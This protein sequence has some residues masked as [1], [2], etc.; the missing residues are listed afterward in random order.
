MMVIMLDQVDWSRLAVG[1]NAN[2]K[3]CEMHVLLFESLSL[4]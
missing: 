1:S 2:A 3:R 4:S